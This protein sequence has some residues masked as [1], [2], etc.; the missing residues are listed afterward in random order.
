MTKAD[1]TRA[2]SLGPPAGD[3]PRLLREGITV[4]VF[5]ERDRAIAW[6]IADGDGARRFGGSW[7]DDPPFLA[8]LA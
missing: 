1:A 2:A 3:D 7:R 4:S 6:L 5:K 8:L